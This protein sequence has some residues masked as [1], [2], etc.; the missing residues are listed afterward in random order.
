MK[1][2]VIDELRPDD[3]Q[4][5]KH[6]LDKNFG[7]SEIEGVY[8]VPIDPEYLSPVQAEHKE[9]EPHYF[10]MILEQNLLACEFLVRT[11]NRMRCNCM[12]YADELQ[13]NWI[14]QFADALFETMEI[15][16]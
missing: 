9:C 11:K 16:I 10:V 12:G 1:Q 3:H 15:K 5:V 2:Y 13:R 4:K 14:I 7:S 8:W 6:F